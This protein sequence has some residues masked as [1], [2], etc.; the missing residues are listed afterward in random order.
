MNQLSVTILICCINSG[1][2]KLAGPGLHASDSPSLSRPSSA[3]DASRQAVPMQSGPASNGCSRPGNDMQVHGDSNG[4]HHS[5]EA[6]TP[7]AITAFNVAFLSYQATIML[8]DACCWLQQ[9]ELA[10][11]SI[12]VYSS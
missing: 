3:D 7:G 9:S 1:G 5:S 4:L 11:V 10:V 8:I 12:C 6:G 2:C